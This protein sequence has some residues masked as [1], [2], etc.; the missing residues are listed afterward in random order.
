MHSLPYPSGAKVR[1]LPLE[2]VFA[3]PDFKQHF[4]SV[5]DYHPVPSVSLILAVA[6]SLHAQAPESC[7]LECV[8]EY[9]SLASLVYIYYVHRYFYFLFNVSSDDIK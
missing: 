1:V 8:L 7:G 5:E 3:A 2:T 6:K 9:R 4:I